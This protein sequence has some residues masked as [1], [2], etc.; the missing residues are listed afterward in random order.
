V[1]STIYNWVEATEKYPEVTQEERDQMNKLYS[2]PFADWE[3]AE[4]KA[5]GFV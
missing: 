4:A 3:V 1:V 2:G 5:H